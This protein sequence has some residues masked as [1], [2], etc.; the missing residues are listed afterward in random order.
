MGTRAR[1]DRRARR[2]AAWLAVSLCLA[3]NGLAESPSRRVLFIGNSFTY[4]NDMP[5]MVEALS[6]AA[7]ASWLECSAVTAP[8]FSLADHWERSDARARIAKGGWDFVVLQQGPSASAE[9]RASLWKDS[10]RFAEL[11]RK[12]GATPALYSVWPSAARRLDFDG[13]A[14]SYARAAEDV[15]GV[16]LPVG[17]AWQAAWK[18]DPE[19]PLY[20]PDGLHPTLAASYLAALVIYQG[21]SGRS[22]I[23]LP[24]AF[25]LGSGTRVE[26]P[27][28][29]AKQLQEAAAEASRDSRPAVTARDAAAQPAAPRPAARPV[30]QAH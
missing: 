26:L 14:A 12:A 6:R 1:V 28:G 27:I 24:A 4:Y 13:V 7:G 23:G 17:A 3:A 29:Q 19:L 15:G 5:A 22:P 18:R 11:I 10:R 21:L 20:D 2:A 9:G 16:L 8:A 25:A 30:A